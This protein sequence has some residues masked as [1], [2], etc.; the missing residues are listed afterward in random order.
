MVI[1]NFAVLPDNEQKDFATALLNKINTEK[2]FTEDT[3]FE[4]TNLEADD[5]TGG[6]WLGISHPDP[7]YVNRKATWICDDED[8]ASNDPGRD[9]DYSEYLIDE[10]KKAF[11]TLSTEIDGYQVSLEIVDVEDTDT[12]EVEVENISH[13]D[14]GIGDY[15][16]FGFRG[17]DSQPYI[18]VTGTITRVCECVLA[19]SV[20]P[21]DSYEI[22]DDESEEV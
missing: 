2:I 21:I 11:K 3:N 6:L 5:I 16:Y 19:L 20:L 13:E 10:A 9:A 4:L 8:K 17:N 15:E 7:I 1:E 18:E 14:A 12:V 22:V